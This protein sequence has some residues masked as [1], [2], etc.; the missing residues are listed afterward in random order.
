MAPHRGR[1]RK[2]HGGRNISGLRNQKSSS[3]LPSSTRINM[4]L[5]SNTRLDWGLE[6]ELRSDEESDIDEEIYW[7]ELDSEILAKQ[8]CRK[9]Q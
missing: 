5:D 4:V 3:A 2:P 8:P 6:D 7:E 9:E 1:G